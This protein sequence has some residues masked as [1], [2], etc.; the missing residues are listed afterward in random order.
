[1]TVNSRD[2]F[3]DPLL[4]L[5]V[6]DDEAVLKASSQYLSTLFPFHVDTALSGNEALTSI[7]NRH[8]DAIVADY[9]MD[10]MSGLDL[11]KKIRST[12]DETPFII[13]TGKGREEVVIASIDN[14][15]DGYVQKGGEIRSQFAELSQ[16]ITTVVKKR[17]AEKALLQSE[18]EYRQ[19]YNK[20]PLAYVT[21]DRFGT[22]IRC[23][24]K[25][26]EL[27][28]RSPDTLTGTSALEIYADLPEG[29]NRFTEIFE[30]FLKGEVNADSELIIIRADGTH[31]WVNLSM[32]AIRDE[33]GHI[34]LSNSILHDITDKKRAEHDLQKAQKH[35]RDIHRQACIGIW[36]WDMGKDRIFWSDELYQI[37]GWNQDLPPPGYSDLL[38]LYV[39]ESWAR[40]QAAVTTAIETGKPYDLELE[41]FHP[42]KTRIWVRAT[43]GPVYDST[44]MLAGL[45]GT[46]QEIT[47]RKR[48]EEALLESEERFRQLFNHASD[49][50]Y[51]HTITDHG[52]GQFIE[53]N[54]AA[55]QML[56]YTRDELL[57]MRVPDINTPESNEM[58]PRLIPL[59]TQN[60]HIRFECT[61]QKKDGSIVPVEVLTHT[62]VLGNQQVVLSIC[63]DISERKHDEKIREAILSGLKD[64]FVEYVDRDLNVIW[65][66]QAT[67]DRYGLTRQSLPGFCY[68]FVQGRDSPCPGC[69]AK[70]AIETGLFQEGEV[71]TPDG[72]H[73]LVRSNPVIEN[74]VVT[75]AIH[76][77]I[78]ITERKRA[79]D[80]LARSEQRLY[81]IIEF[82]PDATFVV[83]KEGTVIAWNKAIEK[84]TGVRASDIIGKGNYEYSLPF[85]QERRP[86]LIDLAMR[87][88]N[89]ISKS[90]ADFQK[91]G[92][93]VIS[94]SIIA[95]FHG[96]DVILWSIASPLFDKSGWFTG[97]IESIRDVTDRKMTENALREAHD[98]LNTVMDSVDALVYVADMTTHEVLF[99]NQYG[100]LLSGDVIGNI[101]Y[102]SLQ[103][104]FDQPCSFCTNHLLLDVA[105]NPTG[106]ITWEF[107]NTIT[108][109][110]YQCRDS[111]IR[112]LDG[113]IVRL[114]IATDITEQKAVEYAL[115]QA[116]LQLSMLSGITRH[117][118]LNTVNA[119]QLFLDLAKSK[120][121]TAPAHQE[122][123]QIEQAI[124][125]I[126]SQIE[127][128]RVY[129]DLGSHL[130]VWHRLSSLIQAVFSK[131]SVHV[132]NTTYDIELYAD[133]M[134][135]KV[136]E[137]L[138]DNSIRHGRNVTR[139]QI[140]SQI[141][142]EQAVIL[143]E[144]DGAGVSDE[145]KEQIFERG[146]GKNT[147]LGLFFIREILSVTGI[148]IRETGQPGTGARFEF[149][150]PSGIWRIHNEVSGGEQ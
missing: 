12:G 66:N 124:S 13:F 52:P 68:R 57:S 138:V 79:E 141:H 86:I 150:I 112:W 22:I 84:M 92:H 33:A 104:G 128:T 53:V 118:I 32:E 7:A 49:A 62:F 111:A 50:I 93:M 100:K 74:G 9:E 6:D 81:D 72:H 10:G 36:D 25:A 140:S 129:Q 143:F 147:G 45:H 137:N 17:R 145:E 69:T 30:T 80:G 98:T 37:I 70:K 132:V 136:F 110:W 126:Q 97:A 108:K 123:E 8:Y 40:L 130:P 131:F 41:L 109:R 77:A 28:G 3:S 99:I 113:R 1:M 35:L 54:D 16:K 142:E 133:P 117:D 59:L 27:L 63:R 21:V 120:V 96:N 38:H 24:T 114:E 58:I 47:Q 15:A 144:D 105:G 91:D 95:N 4:L 34:I 107:Q 43:G 102:R 115:R 42:E 106:T 19:L 139:I 23:N 89:N 88:D 121:D 94:E 78:D 46:M 75:G 67:Y 55:C 135:V 103:K 125:L 5:I 56:G 20:S 18:A 101:C 31:R 149:T 29:R 11:L 39:P 64:I 73:F 26:G 146:Y 61:H 90:Y 116:N 51:L 82:L 87:S 83:D 48:A 85:Y 60:A 119:M 71:T 65:V 44:G 134:L 148:S 122:F 76:I 127:F 14:G 2:V